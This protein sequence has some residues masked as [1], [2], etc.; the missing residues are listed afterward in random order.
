MQRGQVIIPGGGGAGARIGAPAANPAGNGDT[1]AGNGD[2]GA[3]AG[4]AGTSSRRSG[5]L[6][7]PSVEQPALLSQQLR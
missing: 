7:Q 1:G 5:A 4:T 6:E 3:G 2:A